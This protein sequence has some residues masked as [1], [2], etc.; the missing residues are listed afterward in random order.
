[1]DALVSTIRGSAIQ[2]Q[3]VLE[4]GDAAAAL[5]AAGRRLQA[6]YTQPFQAHASIGPSC[7][8]A[9]IRPDGGTIWSST[10][11]PYPLLDALA[12]LLEL[13]LESLRVV[14]AEG[15]GSYGHNGA[16]DAAADAALLSRELGR[17]IRVQWSRRDEF[18]WEPYAP[19]MVMDM[20]GALDAD[21]NLAA[22]THDV[23]SPNHGNRPRRGSH[24]LAGQLAYGLV[25]PPVEWFGGGDFNAAVEYVIPNQ[26]VTA[27]WLPSLPFRT[28]AMRTLGSTANVFANE[29][30]MDELAAAAGVDPL[31]FR[32]GHLE[33]DRAREVLNAAARAAGWGA[34]LPAGTGMGLAFAHYDNDAAYVATVARVQVDPASGQVRVSHLTTSLD[35]GLIVNPDGLSNQAEGN[36]IQSLSRALHEQITYDSHTVTS[37][38]WDSY[39][40]LKFSEVPDIEVVLINR[41]DQPIVGAGE[42]TTV[43]TAPA[44]ANAIFAACGARLRDIPFT[45]ARVLAALD[46]R[47]QGI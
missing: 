39:P 41:P 20:A 8:V 12:D 38:D 34:D 30:F 45:P 25:P 47:G 44:V 3:I 37:A 46:S 42:P 7:G 40:I 23:W 4:T 27:H 29:A 1:M 43:C 16:D 36:L 21:G 13:P 15:S 35:C 32:L 33:D 19:A 22:W 9:D 18:L 28:S 26:L 17:P 11:G 31:E 14:Y 6:V 5:G 2:N 24:L 10:Q